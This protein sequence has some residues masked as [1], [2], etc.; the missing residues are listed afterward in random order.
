MRDGKLLPLLA[1]RRSDRPPPSKPALTKGGFF[2][3]V[4]DRRQIDRGL[5]NGLSF[6]F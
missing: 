3:V 4:A 1:M 6:H 5:A 2:Y